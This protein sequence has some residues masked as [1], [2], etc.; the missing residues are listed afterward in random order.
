MLKRGRAKKYYGIE[1]LCFLGLTTFL[2]LSWF[3]NK[4]DVTD[5]GMMETYNAAGLL[6]VIS[7]DEQL[8]DRM[9]L[10]AQ[11]VRNVA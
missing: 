5:C 8:C 7:P 10:L 11:T 2:A 9:V 6:K 1:A 3:C 4:N